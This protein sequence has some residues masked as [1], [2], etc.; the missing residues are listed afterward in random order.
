MLIDYFNNQFLNDLGTIE[1]EVPN[2]T[3]L[4]NLKTF[5]LFKSDEFF[6]ETEWNLIKRDLNGIQNENI[7]NFILTLLILATTNYYFRGNLGKPLLLINM[8]N[9]YFMSTLGGVGLAPRI[10]HPYWIWAKSHENNNISQEIILNRSFEMR[11]LF[12]LVA[13]Q[14]K[15]E[16][17]SLMNWIIND[18][19][20]PD[21]ALY[22]WHLNDFQKED[23]NNI[24]NII[25]DL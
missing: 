12:D 19:L 14:N 13:K 16:S 3:I 4:A 6:G 10:G 22:F 25:F 15:I 9:Q 17:E 11:S 18:E 5:Y 24:I 20:N 8:N 2:K 23:W 7:E 21:I 1:R